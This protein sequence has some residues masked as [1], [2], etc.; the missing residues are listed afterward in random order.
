MSGTTAPRIA[1]VREPEVRARFGV[2]GAG[3][4]DWL[5]RQGVGLPVA[6][7]RVTHWSGAGGGRCLRLGSSE[8][9]VEYDAGCIPTQ[10]P[11]D[12]AWLLL[13]SDHSLLLE[14][15]QWT[16]ALAQLCAFDFQ[17]FTDEPDLVVMT[18]LAGIG[19]T[20]VREPRHADDSPLA[21]RLWCDASYA[22]YLQQCLHHVARSDPFP[23]EPQ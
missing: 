1:G 2:K 20:L 22:P 7:N 8:F 12:G 13:R 14:G 4:M 5:A 10:P 21:L 17:R 23:G 3:A 19:V 6:P 16:T 15:P 11:G 9:L 18:L